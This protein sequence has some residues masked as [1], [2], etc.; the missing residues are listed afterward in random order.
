MGDGQ[1]SGYGGHNAMH[2]APHRGA[3]GNVGVR[4]TAANQL[5]MSFE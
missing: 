3:A 2:P 5:Y 1:Y 4:N